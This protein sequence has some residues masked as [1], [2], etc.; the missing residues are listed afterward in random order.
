[1]YLLFAV[2]MMLRGKHYPWP[3]VEAVGRQCLAEG[4]CFPAKAASRLLSIFSHSKSNH[5]KKK[6]NQTKKRN[7]FDLSIAFS[8]KKEWDP[9]FS[10]NLT[11]LLPR[12]AFALARGL[13]S[14]IGGMNYVYQL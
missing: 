6:I 9:I 8:L 5:F 7:I 10:G 11:I 1:M 3:G 12:H 14:H 4:H 13:V 2:N